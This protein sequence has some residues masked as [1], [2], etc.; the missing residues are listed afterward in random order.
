MGVSVRPHLLVV[1]PA[2]LSDQ[3]LVLALD[4]ANGSCKSHLLVVYTALFLS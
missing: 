4:M 3:K 1:Y 2:L